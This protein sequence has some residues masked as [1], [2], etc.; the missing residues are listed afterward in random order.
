[1]ANLSLTNC[2]D[3]KLSTSLPLISGESTNPATTRSFTIG[4]GSAYSSGLGGSLEQQFLI[5]NTHKKTW[6]ARIIAV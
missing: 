4:S 6:I 1:L 2:A 3:V 5:A